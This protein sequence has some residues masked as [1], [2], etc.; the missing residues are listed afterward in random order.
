MNEVLE[1]LS[2]G[3]AANMYLGTEI[4]FRLV[5]VLVAKGVLTKGEAAATLYAIADGIRRDAD[6]HPNAREMVEVAASTL[7]Q[8]GNVYL[9]ST[10]QEA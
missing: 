1:G 10:S 4:A 5:D 7:E 2:G 6:D 3:V 9:P 8:S